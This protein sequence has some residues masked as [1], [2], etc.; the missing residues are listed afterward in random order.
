MLYFLLLTVTLD[1]MGLGLLIPVTPKL[2]LALSGQGLARAA[3]YGGWL[4][5]SFAAT[6]FFAGPLLGS[7]SDRVGRRPVL[8]T[9]L[10]AFG[11]S[12]VL[13]ALAPTLTWL[14]VAQL[15]T[16]LFG[17]TPA[18]AGA[19]VADISS[20]AERTRHFGTLA[21]AFG[22]GLVIGPAVGGVLVGF[23]LRIPFLVAA[24]LSLVTVIYGALVLPESLQPQLRRAFSWRRANPFGAV[25]ELTRRSHVGPLLAAAFFQRV[26]TAAL[27]ATWPYFSMQEYGWSARQVGYSLAAYGIA[28]VLAQVGVL[29]WIDR[30]IGTRRAAALSLLLLI[31]GYLG[32]AFARGTWVVVVCI[33]LTTMGFMAGPALASL[34]SVRI[35]NDAQGILQGVITSING[36][37]AVL[38][39]LAMPTLFSVFSTGA[40]HIV[41]PGA[42]Y[43]FAALLATI[44]ILFI[45][46]GAAAIV[47]ERA[48]G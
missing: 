41:F 28:T 43:L 14:F 32:F 35:P 25:G 8:L 39:P 3:V 9:S 17:A 24:A 47:P 12:Y 1:T 18:T 40:L 15:L 22:T 34:L 33:P 21:A 11:V 4:M 38:T 31:A 46:R 48:H 19:Y 44:G 16:G 26:A 6:Q 36:V 42:P 29:R 7:I 10:A 5:A 13:M 23:G 37:A 45:E 2:I 20:P 27:P 30:H